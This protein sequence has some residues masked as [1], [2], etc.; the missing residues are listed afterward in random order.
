LQSLHGFE[1]GCALEMDQGMKSQ[2]A[3][4]LIVGC[5]AVVVSAQSPS[6]SFPRGCSRHSV[7]V[8]LLLCRR[9]RPS[10]FGVEL[11]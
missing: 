5:A 9:G 11:Q 1:L 3:L 6:S 8:P 10:D 2:I 7:R 4:A